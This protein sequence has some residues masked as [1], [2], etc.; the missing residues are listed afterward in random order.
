MTEKNKEIWKQFYKI[1]P[2]TCIF[3]VIDLWVSWFIMAAFNEKQ[4][5]DGAPV[6]LEFVHDLKFVF[7]FMNEIIK[8]HQNAEDPC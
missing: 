7:L 2:E 3:I 4:S 1:W 8:F 6:L 5:A